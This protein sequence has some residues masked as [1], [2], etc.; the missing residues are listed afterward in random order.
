MWEREI[1]QGFSD[2]D[3]F[4]SV[5][6]EGVSETNFTWKF[7]FGVSPPSE[8]FPDDELFKPGAYHVLLVNRDEDED[9]FTHQ[10]LGVCLELAT[11]PKIFPLSKGNQNAPI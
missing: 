2:I 8:I 3:I 1:R 9:E 4:V 6:E 5:G 7:K 11:V 10:P